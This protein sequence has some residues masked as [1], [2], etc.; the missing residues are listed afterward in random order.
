[1]L[2]FQYRENDVQIAI[3]NS[4]LCM[5]LMYVDSDKY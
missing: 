4:I 2:A 5:N 1:M 3:Q